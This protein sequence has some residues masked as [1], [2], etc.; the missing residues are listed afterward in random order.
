ML[1]W[2]QECRVALAY[3]PIKSGPTHY[4]DVVILVFDQPNQPRYARRFGH[5]LATHTEYVSDQFL[6]HH[7]V[8]GLQP[9]KAQQQLTA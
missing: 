2:S 8:V 7:Q 5:R 6:G 9:I 1:H 4:G 3:A